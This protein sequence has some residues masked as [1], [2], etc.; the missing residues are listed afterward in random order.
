MLENLGIPHALFVSSNS[1]QSALIGILTV[2]KKASH[3]C[4]NVSPGAGGVV[5]PKSDR[6]SRDGIAK[7]LGRAKRVS[8]FT[9]MG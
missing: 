1:K 6:C 2:H 3:I 9:Q 4:T 5:D 7:A 8:S